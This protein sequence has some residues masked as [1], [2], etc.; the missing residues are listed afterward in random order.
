MSF[1]RMYTVLIKTTRKYTYR[2]PFTRVL[3]ILCNNQRFNGIL[4]P[5]ECELKFL[6]VI[7]KKYVLIRISLF[8]INIM[9]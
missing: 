9:F 4:E 5:F 6:T 3:I 8:I 7:V 1:N 2:I